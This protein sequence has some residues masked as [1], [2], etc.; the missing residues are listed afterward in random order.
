MQS[1]PAEY[2]WKARLSDSFP[3][4]LIMKESV[5]TFGGVVDEYKDKE[6]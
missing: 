3:G 1:F 2:E 5:Q 4:R 6:N